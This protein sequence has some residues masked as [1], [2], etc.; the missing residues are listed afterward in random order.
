M[1]AQDSIDLLTNCG[2]Q[3]KRHDEFGLDVSQFA[4]LLMTSGVVLTEDVRWISFHRYRQTV[5][6]IVLDCTVVLWRFTGLQGLQFKSWYVFKVVFLQDQ[7]CYLHTSSCYSG[8]TTNR[9]RKCT[10][11]MV[12]IKIFSCFQTLW[13]LAVCSWVS[14]A[15]I[16]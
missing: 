13:N 5:N 7:H 2:I 16:G 8:E 1:Y 11:F 14:T 10:V 3:F 12:F 9:A 15:S 4:E 6:I